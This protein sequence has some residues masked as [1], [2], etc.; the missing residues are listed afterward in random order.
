MQATF[1]RPHRGQ[2]SPQGARPAAARARGKRTA[3]RALR[4]RGGRVGVGVAA[5]D[6]VA[7]FGAQQGSECGKGRVGGCQQ[8][9]SLSAR[10]ARPKKKNTHARVFCLSL[11]PHTHSKNSASVALPTCRTPAASA[12]PSAAAA[13]RA[14]STAAAAR[15]SRAVIGCRLVGR[16]GPPNARHDARGGGVLYVGGASQ[17]G[18]R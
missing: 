4:R 13:A 11:P 1:H 15:R 7:R 3:A 6:G 18:T 5:V 2:R 14:A 9:N 10:V 17:R 16:E 12:P 8:L